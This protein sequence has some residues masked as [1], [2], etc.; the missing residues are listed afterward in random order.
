MIIIT[1]G[2]V[3]HLFYIKTSLILYARGINYLL[4]FF[5]MI[6]TTDVARPSRGAHGQGTVRGPQTNGVILV[7]GPPGHCPPAWYAPDNDVLMLSTFVN[8]DVCPGS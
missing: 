5:V 1:R 2:R 6:T 8:N 7:E 3:F 4:I